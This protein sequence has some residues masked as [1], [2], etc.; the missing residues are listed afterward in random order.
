MPGQALRAPGCW[1]LGGGGAESSL[2]LWCQGRCLMQ[3]WGVAMA[4]C[5]QTSDLYVSQS[6]QPCL[7]PLLCCGTSV[8][9]LIGSTMC[10]PSYLCRRWLVIQEVST[11]I[12]EKVMCPGLCLCEEPLSV[13]HG[14]RVPR[15]NGLLGWGSPV[16]TWRVGQSHSP[17]LSVLDLKSEGGVT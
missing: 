10:T 13:P 5:T 7:F 8:A 1:E 9:L 16:G 17:P 6:T 11:V 14:Q 2:C 15:P 3:A 4:W 12:E